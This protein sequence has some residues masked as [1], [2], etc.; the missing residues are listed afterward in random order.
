MCYI[1][2]A[3]NAS[4]HF[5][6]D[7]VVFG[8]WKMRRF[9]QCQPHAPPAEITVERSYPRSHHYHANASVLFRF[10]FAAASPVFSILWAWL[11]ECES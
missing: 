6:L 10:L 9:K 8:W 2:L 7:G 11:G 3:S 1:V 4:M 5:R